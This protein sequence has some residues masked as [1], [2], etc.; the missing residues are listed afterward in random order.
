M[1]AELWSGSDWPML[2]L[3]SRP[4]VPFQGSSDRVKRSD[5]R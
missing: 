3:D 4:S 1:I 5:L 2:E